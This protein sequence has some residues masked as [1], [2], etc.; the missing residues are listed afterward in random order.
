MVALNSDVLSPADGETVAAGPLEIRGYAF[1]GGERHVDRVDAPSTAATSWSQAE[2]LDDLGPWAWRHWRITVDLAPGEDEIVVRAWD[3]SAATQP[4]DEAALRNPKGYVEQRPPAGE[5]ASRALNS[6]THGSRTILGFPLRFLLRFSA[7]NLRK[8]RPGSGEPNLIG[9]SHAVICVRRRSSSPARQLTPQAKGKVQSRVVSVSALCRLPKSTP[10]DRGGSPRPGI[11][12]GLLAVVLL[13]ALFVPGSVALAASGGAG[14][15]TPVTPRGIVT[16]P[17]G[18]AVFSRTLRVGS[19][20]QD[21]KTLQA[22]LSDVGFSVSSTGLFGSKTRHAVVAFQSANALRPV[23]GTVG[24]RTASALL[25]A[26][27]QAVE[28]AAGITTA[29]APTVGAASGTLLFPLQ[30]IARVLPPSSW[31][32]DQGIDIGTVGNACGAH[33]VEVAVADGKIVQEGISGFGPYAPILKVSDGPYAGR[34][35]YY[36]HAAPALVPVGA[37]VIAGE[38]IAEVGCGDVGISS[39][40]HIEIGISAP[41]DSAPCCVGYLETSPALLPVIEAAYLAAG[42]RG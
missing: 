20:G 1:A 37:Q 10:N 33:V 12:H 26:V 17:A 21:V 42:G 35:I 4:E 2:L 36:G 39:S 7:P 14:L 5:G 15:V 19:R 25:A 38:P 13:L 31:T 9:A 3:S 8:A 22:W 11:L 27:K 32:L 6:V 16:A 29:P 34:Y 41:G 18:G 40:P 28:H 23:T 24:P 30:P